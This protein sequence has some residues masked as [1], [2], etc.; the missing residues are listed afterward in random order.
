MAKQ[1]DKKRKANFSTNELKV[2]VEEMEVHYEFLSAKFCDSVTNARKDE[3]WRTIATKVNSVAAAS[4]T[5]ADIRKKW[6]DIK[7]RTK[8]RASEI[9]KDAKKTGGGEPSEKPLTDIEEKIIDVIGKTIVYGL[10][11]V[12]TA[13]ISSVTTA[14]SGEEDVMI[15]ES[16]PEEPF[17]GKVELEIFPR[18]KR[19]KVDGDGVKDVPLGKKTAGKSDISENA[20][21]TEPLRKKKEDVTKK[22]SGKGEHKEILDLMDIERRRLEIDERRLEIDEKRLLMEER[23]LEMEE[24]RIELEERRVAVEEWQA[25]ENTDENQNYKANESTSSYTSL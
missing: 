2:L 12:D 24:K 19:A 15:M 8:K 20:K 6:D 3:I 7:S 13:S 16:E 11:G 1:G 9:H 25:W 23:M 10:P 22:V 17:A 18:C 5:V 4:R 14:D 21:L